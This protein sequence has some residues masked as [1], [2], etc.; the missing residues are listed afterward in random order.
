[1]KY[2]K[3]NNYIKRIKPY[4]GKPIIKVLTGQRR[5]GKS[6]IMLQLHDEINALDNKANNIYINCELEEFR[7]LKTTSDLYAYVNSKLITGKNNYL[8]IDEVQ[9]I[10]SFQDTLRSLLTEQKCDIYCTGSNANILSS[11]LATY[12]S[13]RYMEFDIHSLSYQEFLQFHELEN[14]QDSL[15]KY[16]TFGGMPFLINLE[17]TREQSFEYLSNVYSTILLKD[18]V[19][20]EKIRNISFLENLV[21]YV[22]DNI[23][24]L[25]SSNNISKY[26]KSQQIQMSPQLIINY[27]K[28]LTNAYIIHKVQRADIGGLKIFEIGEKYYFE[29]L[30]LRNMIHGA[31]IS[32]ELHKLMENAVFL[33]LLQSGYKIF[34]GKLNGKEIDFMADKNG[35]KIYIQVTL[36]AMEEKTRKREFGNLTEIDDNYPKYVI[37]LNDIIIGDDYKGIKYCNLG[38]FLLMNI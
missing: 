1:M 31:N 20:K 13:G 32:S 18:V 16:L 26:L 4:I 3:R 17:L 10:D 33:H 23:G 7:S 5:V 8:F 2:I 19:E 14:S 11:E 37:T 24:S 25:F 35:Q 15:T 28:G 22:A 6:C 36:T 30:G 21:V 34:V 9:E 38:D 27:L 29:D 12:L